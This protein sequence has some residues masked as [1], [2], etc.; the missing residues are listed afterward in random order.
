MKLFALV[1]AFTFAT[2][3][4]TPSFA[5]DVVDA[6]TL[7]SELMVA[8]N[9][10][11]VS[12]PAAVAEG[13]K[14]AEQNVTTTDFYADLLGSL[15]GMV[16]ASALAIAGIVVAFLRKW[17]ATPLANQYFTNT[18]LWREAITMVLAWA[19]GVIALMT[20]AGLTFGAAFLH[21]STLGLAVIA[22]AAIFRAYNAKV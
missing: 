2:M 8:Q 17:I 6:E 11:E 4:G 18:P 16:G 12:V 14:E 19:G 3:I 21:S 22:G 13:E 15:G 7:H 1:L 20:S 5:T 10:V 9:T